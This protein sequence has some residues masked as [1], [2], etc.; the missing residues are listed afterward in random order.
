MLDT[1]QLVCWDAAETLARFLVGGQPD[2]RLFEKEV[3]TALRQVHP[4]DG[5]EGLRAYGDMV[6]L[7]LQNRQ[8]AAAQRLEQLWNKLMEQSSIS[9]FCA[10]L[11][12]PFGT[13]CEVATLENL[14]CMHT[15]LIPADSH[16]LLEP[17]LERAMD[18]VLGAHSWRETMRN[19]C[20][21]AWAVMPSAESIVLWLRKYFPLQAD[22]IISQAREHYWRQIRPAAAAD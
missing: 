9:L 2:W 11:L 14:L 19:N 7:L 22:G 21:S 4:S 20:R 13:E 1:R 5:V 6:G 10:Y 12:D 15:H 17:A 3:C 16:G 8:F 18:D